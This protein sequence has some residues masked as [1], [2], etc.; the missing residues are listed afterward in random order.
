MWL[1]RSLAFATAALILGAHAWPVLATPADNGADAMTALGR[2]LD[3]TYMLGE[4]DKPAYCKNRYGIAEAGFDYATQAFYCRTAERWVRVMSGEGCVQQFGPGAFSDP[5]GDKCYR[6]GGQDPGPNVPRVQSGSVI[7]IERGKVDVPFG[8]DNPPPVAVMTP[9]QF[10]ST[11]ERG[12]EREG[13]ADA[14][15]AG[16]KG[17]IA[18]F[19]GLPMFGKVLVG[20]TF[21]VVALWAGGFAMRLR[22]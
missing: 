4:L 14:P 7:R 21:L 13:V 3:T 17:P 2:N 6:L 8:D 20:G 18:A 1:R 22:P 5:L 9:D 15:A 12:V 16:D 10:R 11:K 19:N